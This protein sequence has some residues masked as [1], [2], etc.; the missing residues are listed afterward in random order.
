MEGMKQLHIFPKTEK[1]TKQSVKTNQLLYEVM[2]QAS[3][4][5]IDKFYLQTANSPT[6]RK[7]K[8]LDI[9]ARDSNANWNIERQDTG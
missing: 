1:D 5:D 2:Q 8:A 7:V 6:S 3:S 9:T 4:S